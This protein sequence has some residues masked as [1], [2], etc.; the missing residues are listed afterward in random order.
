MM[1]SKQN[2]CQSAVLKLFVI[3]VNPSF[4]MEVEKMTLIGCDG[5][6]PSGKNGGFGSRGD[7][8]VRL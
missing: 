3:L 1:G 5:G 8:M 4:L 7:G 6:W 2:V